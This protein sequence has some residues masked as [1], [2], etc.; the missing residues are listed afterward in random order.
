MRILVTGGAGFIGSHLVDTLLA[1]GHAVTVL[2]DFSTGKISNLS[3]AQT[4]GQIEV[5]AGSVLDRATL[6]RVL[7]GAE[8]VFHLAVQGV[9]RSLGKP[10]EN[11]D[12]NATGTLY[13]LEAGRRHQVRRF[14]YCSSSEVYGNASDGPL[15]EQTAVCAPMTVYGAS[16]LA[17]EHYSLAYWRTYGM[18]TVVVRPF[19]S[20]GPREHDQGDLAEVIPRFVI[21]ALNGRRP[22]IF[23]DGSQGR[24]FTY[25][26]E[27]ARG[28]AAALNAEALVGSVVNLGRGRLVTIGE[29]A[30]TVLRQ[31]GK[32][33]LGI[34]YAAPR[35]G[36]I[37]RLIADTRRAKT[38]IGF[39]P[40]VDI[41]EGMRRYLSWFRATYAD[42]AALLEDCVV[43][44]RLPEDAQAERVS[45]LAEP[46]LRES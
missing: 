18:P 24:D 29:L 33:E 8:A 39:D 25:V 9:R 35:P 40:Q 4:S 28:L 19:N 1:E 13:A 31:C 22:V 32:T 7:Q 41:E 42:P 37:H 15:D 3:E 44:W 17:G 36:D 34:E 10:V 21:R 14:I 6:D 20:Y 43:N 2:D 23:G 5:I 12:V 26:T 30:N 16:K 38:T 45:G 11:H 46:R 27:T